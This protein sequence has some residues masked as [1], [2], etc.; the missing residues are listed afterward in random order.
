ML[1]K[2]SYNTFHSLNLLFVHQQYPIIMFSDVLPYFFNENFQH[3][4]N[5]PCHSVMENWQLWLPILPENNTVATFLVNRFYLNL[6]LKTI[7][8]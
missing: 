1:N 4:F 2:S 5:V 7:L 8:H 3:V 6:H